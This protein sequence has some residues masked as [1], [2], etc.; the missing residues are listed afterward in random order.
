MGGAPGCGHGRSKAAAEHGGEVGGA[1]LAVPS[2][3]HNLVAGAEIPSGATEFNL[4]PYQLMSFAAPSG[5]PTL[6]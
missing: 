3:T 5:E 2:G 6:N 1:Q 4:G